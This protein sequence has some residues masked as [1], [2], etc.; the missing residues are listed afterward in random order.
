M[1]AAVPR[2]DAVRAARAE[3]ENPRR[4]PNDHPV[5]DPSPAPGRSDLGARGGSG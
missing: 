3:A 2:P 5:S 1:L 4:T